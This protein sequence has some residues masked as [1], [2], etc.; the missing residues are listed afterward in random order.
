[1]Y[2]SRFEEPGARLY[3][4]VANVFAAYGHDLATEA[5]ASALKNMTD[6]TLCGITC[7]AAIVRDVCPGDVSETV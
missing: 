2:N 4:D 6:D 5:F 3:A 1:M 7:V